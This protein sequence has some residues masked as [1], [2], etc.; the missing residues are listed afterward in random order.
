M[1]AKKPTPAEK[2]ITNAAGEKIRHLPNGEKHL[3]PAH[4][5]LAKIAGHNERAA[6]EH[7]RLHEI[8]HIRVAAKKAR[9]SRK[10]WPAEKSPI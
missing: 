6:E 2:V 8:K 9:Q 7:A 5:G 1:P 10:G 4:S 3:V